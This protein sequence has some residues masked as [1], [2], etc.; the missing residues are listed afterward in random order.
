[1]PTPRWDN[2][3]FTCPKCGKIIRIL[4]ETST[5]IPD[6]TIYS[7]ECLLSEG[8]GWSGDLPFSDIHP[9]PM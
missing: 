7:V 6:E 5:E 3:F 8:C 1:M 9:L 4:I 2:Y